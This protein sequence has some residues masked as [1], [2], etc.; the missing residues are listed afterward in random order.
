MEY[1]RYPGPIRSRE[2]LPKPENWPRPG[3]TLNL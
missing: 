3:N 1:V 2:H